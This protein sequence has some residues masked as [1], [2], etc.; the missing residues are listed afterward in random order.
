[1]AEKADHPIIPFPDDAARVIDHKFLLE[2][3][4]KKLGLSRAALGRLLKVSEMTVFRWENQKMAIGPDSKKIIE[5]LDRIADRLAEQH[6]DQ[7]L[8]WLE[9]PNP[10]LDNFRPVDLLGSDYGVHRLQKL[11][12]EKTL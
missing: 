10:H 3:R 1:M 9:A 11:I 4:S 7:I 8:R 6:P 12:Q 5:H 2:L